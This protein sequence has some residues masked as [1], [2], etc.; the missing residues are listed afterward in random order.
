MSSELRCRG[1]PPPPR[2][3]SGPWPR[4]I[5]FA[6][7]SR[8]AT[9]PTLTRGRGEGAGAVAMVTGPCLSHTRPPC[10]GTEAKSLRGVGQ[11]GRGGSGDPGGRQGTEEAAETP[12]GQRGPRRGSGESS[13]P[14]GITARL[15][16]Q[17]GRG[18]RDPRGVEGAAWG[19]AGPRW[20]VGTPLGTAGTAATGG[21]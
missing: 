20:G 8:G 3:T 2:F 1:C 10:P 4:L 17:R 5:P 15:V 16:G 7:D 12:R 9:G 13:T 18:G 21:Q 14:G 6:A 19:A 11:E